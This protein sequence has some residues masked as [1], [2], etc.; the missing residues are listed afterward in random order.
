MLAGELV[1]RSGHPRAFAMCQQVRGTVGQDGLN[2]RK[3][4]DQLLY[5]WTIAFRSPSP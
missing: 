1:F 4:L 2:T 5:L 3:L